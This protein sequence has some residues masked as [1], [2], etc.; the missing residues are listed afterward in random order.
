MSA[1]ARSC[2]SLEAFYAADARPRFFDRLDG[3]RPAAAA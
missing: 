2:P 3:R 1:I